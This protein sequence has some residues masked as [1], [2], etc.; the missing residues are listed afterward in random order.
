MAMQCLILK[1]EPIGERDILVTVLTRDGE[2]R[3]ALARSAQQMPSKVRAGTLALSVSDCTFAPGRQQWV[4]RNAY[5]MLLFP[6]FS[7]SFPAMFFTGFWGAFFARALGSEGDRKLYMIATRALRDLHTALVGKENDLLLARRAAGA[8][9]KGL[10]VFGF[11]P[12]FRQCVRCGA[13]GDKTVLVGLS[14]SAGG[15][16][17]GPCMREFHD[18][19]SLSSRA[20]K[21]LALRRIPTARE[22][23]LQLLRFLALFTGWQIEELRLYAQLAAS[24]L[25]EPLKVGSTSSPQDFSDNRMSKRL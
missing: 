11:A 7:S 16:T 24:A 6:A 25:A 22:D 2:V 3:Q 5:L 8:W 23:I 20:A 9:L 18:S 10:E 14:P 12:Q 1:R 19:R 4:L 13:E 17:C 15:I 21:E